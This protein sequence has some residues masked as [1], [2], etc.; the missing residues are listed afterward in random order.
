MQDGVEVEKAI[1]PSRAQKPIFFLLSHGPL[2]GGGRD[3]YR[4]KEREG[5]PADGGD[6]AEGL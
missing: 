4:V 3:T 6:P 2:A 5:D 1:N